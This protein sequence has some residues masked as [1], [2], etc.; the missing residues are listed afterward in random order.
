MVMGGQSKGS[1]KGTSIASPPSPTYG[2][3][4]KLGV[5]DA[6]MSA[7]NTSLADY[8]K[9]VQKVKSMGSYGPD[10]TDLLAKLESKKPTAPTGI[11]SKELLAQTQMG[12]SNPYGTSKVIQN[13]DGSYTTVNEVNPQIQAMLSKALQGGDTYSDALLSQSM[14]KLAPQM[15]A[16]GLPMGSEINDTARLNASM[17]AILGGQQMQQRDIQTAMGLADRVGGA[18]GPDVMGSYNLPFQA[19]SLPYMNDVN[20]QNM[21]YGAQVGN[22]R[23][24]A[25]NASSNKSS[26]MNSLQGL[27]SAAIGPLGL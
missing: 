8:N 2:A 13:P 22:N 9:A 23:Q 10:R 7:Y 1:K 21:I 3:A 17:Q 24:G 20:M 19:Q 15:A 25:V 12:V 4:P 6:E 14:Q 11:G 26:K 16:R 5:S 18:Q 27:G